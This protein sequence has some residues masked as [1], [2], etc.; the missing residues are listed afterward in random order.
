MTGENWVTLLLGLVNVGQVVALAW[1]G[2]EQH[3]SSAERERRIEAD[4][5]R[6]TRSA[7]EG[8]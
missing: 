4:P 5:P 2:R 8:R 6:P 1:I 3:R 7:A